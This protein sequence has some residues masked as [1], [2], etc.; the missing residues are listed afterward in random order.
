[1]IGSSPLWSVKPDP[2][3]AEKETTSQSLAASLA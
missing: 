3:R 1:M 2:Q